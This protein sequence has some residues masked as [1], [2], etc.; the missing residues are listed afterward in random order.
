[1]RA[2]NVAYFS[3]PFVTA[4]IIT[5][6]T[7]TSLWTAWFDFLLWTSVTLGFFQF[8]TTL[9]QSRRA[10]SY[11]LPYTGKKLDLKVAAFVT[12]FNEDPEIVERTLLSVKAAL[13]NRG[14]VILLDDST[15]PE[16]VARLSEFCKKNGIMYFHRA[17]RRGFKAGA[18]NDA[19]KA[20]GD[21]YDLVAIFDADQRPSKSFFDIVL[22]FF[23]DPKVAFV[24]VPQ[25]YEKT[26]SLIGQGARYQQEPFLRRVMRG[27]D[28]RSAFSL[29][30][31]TVYRISVLKE[32]GLLEEETVTEDI[33]TSVK[34]HEKGYVSKY[35]DLP[36]VWYG[37][38]PT[39]V[40]AYITQQSRWA[41]GGFQLL[42]TLLKSDLSFRT[43]M[44][45]ISGIFYWL[46]VGPFT[47]VQVAAPIIFLFGIY[48]LK[49]NPVIYV[50]AYVP[51]F[52]FSLYYFY[53][54]MKG[55]E[56]GV[57]GFLLHQALEY[58]EFIGVTASF[59]AWVLRRKVP[60]K[61]TAK[62]K[63]AKSL[64]PLIYHMII[65]TL[66]VASMTRGI[67]LIRGATL[68]QLWSIGINEF[69]AA[70]H[71]FFLITG[72][73]VSFVSMSEEEK[74]YVV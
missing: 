18:I 70:W 67:F 57:K 6:F 69:W 30:S 10:M 51:Y 28:S 71:Y 14:D 36:L 7:Y 3:M 50:S 29:G 13:G 26:K 25:Y 53:Y 24:Q 23:E 15:K 27:R 60:F 66:L 52:I 73:Y 44:D 48:F 17:N 45:Y 2:V 33:A 34:I 16:I 38:P 22:P 55:T 64:R 1:M 54:L 39:E 32:V 9:S 62:G 58:V 56:Y 8:L 21:N 31:G 72:I 47:L 5:Y 37:T 59:F 41:L 11:S 40:S 35:V 68:L 4:L 46:E 12:A 49:I 42:G 19:I 43:F 20:I 65:L 74:S 63:S 61:V